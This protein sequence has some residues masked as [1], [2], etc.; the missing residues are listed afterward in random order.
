MKNK[1]DLLE[2]RGH[3]GNKVIGDGFKD[4]LGCCLLGEAVVALKKRK[5]EKSNV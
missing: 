3:D 1:V 5:I 4:G 2:R